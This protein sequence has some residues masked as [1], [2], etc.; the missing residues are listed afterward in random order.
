VYL[1]QFLLNIIIKKKMKP[2]KKF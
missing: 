2:P 1:T